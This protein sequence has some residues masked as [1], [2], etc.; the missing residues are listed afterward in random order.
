MAVTATA[1]VLGDESDNSGAVTCQQY[2]LRMRSL[3]DCDM[4]HVGVKQVHCCGE[5]TRRNMARQC[6]P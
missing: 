1:V 3:L 2:A 4:R 6:L 5:L